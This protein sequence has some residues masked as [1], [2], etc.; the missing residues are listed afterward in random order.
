MPS[1]IL[2]GNQVHF[3]QS[4]PRD[5]LR[6]LFVTLHALGLTIHETGNRLYPHAVELSESEFKSV[7]ELA[8]GE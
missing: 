8:K 7:I 1:Y 5:V 3:R 4:F 6:G 2:Q